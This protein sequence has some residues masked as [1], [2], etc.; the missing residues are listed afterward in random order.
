[1]NEILNL[2]EYAIIQNENFK[3]L[4]IQQIGMCQSCQGT[5]VFQRIL[6]P[7]SRAFFFSIPTLSS[8][9]SP[10]F[11]SLTP[12]LSLCYQMD[13]QMLDGHISLDQ[14]F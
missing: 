9:S 5:M 13:I 10:I 11:V 6:D 3:Y 8:K 1:V 14:L 4:I 7:W 12:Q 2:Q